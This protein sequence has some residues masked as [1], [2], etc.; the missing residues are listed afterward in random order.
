MN[1]TLFKACSTFEKKFQILNEIGVIFLNIHLMKFITFSI[2]IDQKPITVMQNIS[3]LL[4]LVAI[5]IYLV[6]SSNTFWH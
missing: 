1:L 4:L 6:L 5:E 3:Y 2:Q